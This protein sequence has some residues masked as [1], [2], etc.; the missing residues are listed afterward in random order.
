MAKIK[1]LNV[2]AAKWSRNASAAGESYREGLAGADWEGPARAA[3]QAY[4]TGVQQ[5]IGRGAFERGIG[6]AGNSKWQQ[7]ATA[8]GVARFGEGVQGAQAAY[9][10]GF[11]PYAQTIASTSLPPKGPK[12]AEGNIE[13]VRAIAR[14]L[15]AAKLSR[16]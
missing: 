1:A 6:T 12:G 7:A 10:E 16:G 2:I 13:R 15:R 5:A 3:A 8:K 11:G 9:Q 4:A 14:A